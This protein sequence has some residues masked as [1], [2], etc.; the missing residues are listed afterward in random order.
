MVLRSCT[1]CV[2]EEKS[3]VLPNSACSEREPFLYSDAAQKQNEKC[4]QVQTV[5]TGGE[6][7]VSA[8]VHQQC[9]FR[10]LGAAYFLCAEPGDGKKRTGS[11]FSGVSGSLR[12]IIH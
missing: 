3:A 5:L 4:Q 10:N 8:K 12:I 2:K 11:P 7:S 6:L 1:P 9:G